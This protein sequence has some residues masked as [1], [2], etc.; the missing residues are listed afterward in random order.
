MDRSKKSEAHSMKKDFWRKELKVSDET[1]TMRR[2]IRE[3]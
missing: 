3:K 2:D 1:E